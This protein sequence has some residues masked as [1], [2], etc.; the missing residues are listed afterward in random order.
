MPI[1]YV[2]PPLADSI[3]D[4]LIKMEEEKK[5][6]V[7]ES[8]K[9]QIAKETKDTQGKKEDFHKATFAI[10]LSSLGM[11]AMIAMGKLENPLSGKAETNYDQARFL[12][13]TLEIIKEKTKN[14]LNSQEETLLN[15]YL[16]N[17]RMMYVEAKKNKMHT[18]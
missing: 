18:D 3:S 5:K 10:F 6:K 8:W 17:L 2:R 7:D 15:D 12:I 11:Q 9:E 4:A 14:N 16:F 13:D 1:T